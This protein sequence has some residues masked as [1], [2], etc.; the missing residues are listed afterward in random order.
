MII[1]L[2]VLSYSATITVKG[3]YSGAVWNKGEGYIIWWTKSG[4]MNAKVKIRLY[5]GANK[6]LSITNSAP[7]NG[8]FSWQIPLNLKVGTY[9]IRVKTIDNKVFDDSASFKIASVH[10][11]PITVFSPHKGDVWYKGNSYDIAWSTGCGQVEPKIK[12]SLYQGKTKILDIVNS[13]QHD[14]SFLWKIPKSLTSGVYYIR[15]K[16]TDNIEY[17]DSK[18]FEIREF[19]LS[20]AAKKFNLYKNFIPSIK[21]IAP[22]KGSIWKRGNTYTIKWSSKGLKISRYIKIR[23]FNEN[24]QK[25]LRIVDSLPNNGHFP[26]KIPDFISP[27][28]YYIRI[29]TRDNKIF[30]DGEH[31]EIK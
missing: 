8:S 30:H 28:M 25:V 11:D 26:W 12:I 29:K 24:G 7:N 31:F 27:G 20:K 5:Q 15:V 6:I 10:Y 3:P 19:S 22:H 17:G 13:T 9:V 16:T 1:F 2:V 23:L 21:I 4:I 18:P 14:G